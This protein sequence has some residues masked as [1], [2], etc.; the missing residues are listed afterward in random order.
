MAA[1]KHWNVPGFIAREKVSILPICNNLGAI[2]NYISNNSY[3]EIPMILSYKDEY[4]DYCLES[5]NQGVANST[6]SAII[7]IPEELIALCGNE[8]TFTFYYSGETNCDYLTVYRNGTEIKKCN[9]NNGSIYLQDTL[10]LEDVVAGDVFQFTFRKDGSENTGLDGCL[11]FITGY[12]GEKAYEITYS[13]V[14][15]PDTLL[16]KLIPK[17]EN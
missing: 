6:S 7:T 17:E 13:L 15:N 12:K 9:G 1:D 3:T 5:Q 14:E 16:Y 4:E 8:Y 11:I 10:Y 2:S